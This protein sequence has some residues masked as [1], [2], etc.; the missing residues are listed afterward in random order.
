VS[1]LPQQVKRRRAYDTTKRRADALNRRAGVLAAARE[2]F[3]QDGFAATTVLAVAERAGVSQET[4]YKRFGGKPG[5]VRALHD[6]AMRGEDPIS[7]YRRSE[8]LRTHPDPY[9]IVRGWSRLSTEV[10]PRASPILLL[11]RDAALVQPRLR[12]LLTELD[13]VRHQRMSENA[14]FLHDAGHLRQGVTSRTAADLMWSVTSPEMY[15]LLVLRRGWSLDQYAD[16]IFHTVTGLLKQA[17]NHR[18]A[19]PRA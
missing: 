6:D 18:A 8:S 1:R 16:Y 2:L 14:Q 9:E 5:L 19:D 15:E 4:V 17:E 10:A 11:V 3:L 13:D 7:P 12:D